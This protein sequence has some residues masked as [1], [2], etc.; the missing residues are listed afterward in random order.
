MN[1]ESKISCPECGNKIN[2]NEILKNQYAA[3]MKIDFEQQVRNFRKNEAIKIEAKVKEEI[4]EDNKL[5]F[6]DLI[7]KNRSLKQ[8]QKEY[9]Q[10]EIDLLDLKKKQDEIIENHEIDTKKKIHY[11]LEKQKEKSKKNAEE[12]YELT[13]NLLEKQLTDQKK[14]TDEMRRKQEQGSV[15]L[16]GEVMELAIERWLKDKFP[17]DLIEEIKVGANGADCLQTVK[18]RDSANCGK[19]YYESKRTKS[20]Q[21]SWIE[22]FKLDMREKKADIGVL[23]TETMP[24][25]MERMGIRDGIYICNYNEFK[26]ISAVLRESIIQINRAMKVNENKGDK[27]NLLYNFLTSP[28]FK[29]QIEGVVEGFTIMQQDLIKEKNSIKRM[30]KQR[31]KQLEKIVDN[32]INMYGSLKGIAGDSVISIKSLDNPIKLNEKSDGI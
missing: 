13:I 6:S 2:I 10:M 19:I 29:L 31:E 17:W 22:K 21:P 5:K 11:A 14:L 25:D 7:N 30:W 26:G 8:K 18:T 3:K 24:N 15:Q 9:D 4:E 28:E 12:K 16:Q 23:V 20:F 27:I 32:T 1:T